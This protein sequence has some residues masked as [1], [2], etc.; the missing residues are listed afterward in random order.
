MIRVEHGD[1]L[2]VIPRL[3]AEG[4][5]ADAIVTDPPYGLEFMGKL[6]DAPLK[7]WETGAQFTKPGIGDRETTWPAF[8]AF[9]AANPTCAVC[10][11]R[12]RGARKCSCVEPNWKPI[13]KRRGGPVKASDEPLPAINKV[14]QEWCETWAKSAFRVL[15][16]GGYILAFWGHA[17]TSPTLVR[18]RRWIR[19]SR[20]HHVAAWAGISER[21][22]AAKAS[23]GTHLSR[24]QTG[25]QTL[26]AD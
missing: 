6:W 14:Y 21:Q 18:D 12:A 22:D 10:G 19:H 26:S 3:V 4:I 17:H 24:V 25:R 13:G 8:G 15:K 5:V 16:R 7:M 11:G 9:G 23:L 1:M 2:E 20:H